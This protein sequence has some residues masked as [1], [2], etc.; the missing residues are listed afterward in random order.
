M[1]V[2]KLSDIIPTTTLLVSEARPNSGLRRKKARRKKGAAARPMR[3]PPSRYKTPQPMDPG[4]WLQK[5]GKF[6]EFCGWT[7]DGSGCYTHPNGEVYFDGADFFETSDHDYLED[8]SIS[9]K[10]ADEWL[11]ND[12]NFTLEKI[13]T[14]GKGKVSTHFKIYLK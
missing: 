4:V 12:V 9:I 13:K 3:P 7:D 10:T 8:L 2:S 11:A 14:I 1:A 5:F 6:L